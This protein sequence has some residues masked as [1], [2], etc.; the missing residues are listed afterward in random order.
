[1]ITTGIIKDLHPTLERGAIELLK[2]LQK[3]GYKAIILD[4]ECQDSLYQNGTEKE[5]NIVT[6]IKDG[7]SI[8]NYKLS[9]CVARNS[10]IELFSDL[11]FF[12]LAGEI[13]TQMGGEWGGN[14]FN[15]VDRSY[16][17]FIGGL[18][19]NEL[20]EGKTLSI[21]AK[22]KWEDEIN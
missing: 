7:Q 10:G 14:S 19:L 22:M 5:G 13:W 21:D 3:R 1:M 15:I 16:M 8:Q 2:R 11:K 17:Q 12:N 6:N 18:T 9:F 4:A 20:K